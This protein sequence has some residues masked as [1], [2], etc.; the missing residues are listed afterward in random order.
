[1]KNFGFIKTFCTMPLVNRPENGCLRGQFSKKVSKKCIK[2]TYFSKNFSR[3]KTQPQVIPPLFDPWFRCNIPGQTWNF[4]HH[5]LWLFDRWRYKILTY[6]FI[7]AIS[8]LQE[9]SNYKQN[10]HYNVDLTANVLKHQ[11]LFLRTL[12]K[13]SLGI[14]S[15]IT[16]DAQYPE[17][18]PD[19]TYFHCDMDNSRHNSYDEI[20]LIYHAID[21]QEITKQMSF[22]KNC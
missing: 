8:F 21:S 3:K 17:G 1:M 12:F 5:C 16:D 15:E 2:K 20:I 6:F 18:L 13:K 11:R 7:Q 4:S 9:G 19:P 14:V 22:R 10:F